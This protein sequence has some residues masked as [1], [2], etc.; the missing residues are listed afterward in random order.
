MI[1]SVKHPIN[2]TKSVF[3]SETASS[4]IKAIRHPVKTM[5]NVPG[6]LSSGAQTVLNAIKSTDSTYAQLVQQYG[7]ENVAEVLELFAGYTV[8]DEII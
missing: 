8:S 3:K 5:K 4:I 6:N 2:T 7:Y 1:D